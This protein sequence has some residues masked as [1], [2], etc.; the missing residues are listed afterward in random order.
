[1][2][3]KSHKSYDKYFFQRTHTHTAHIYLY[4]Y[5]YTCDLCHIYWKCV[6]LLSYDFF[7]ASGSCNLSP[8]NFLPL[9]HPASLAM[10]SGI[11]IQFQPPRCVV[12]IVMFS[13]ARLGEC[14][15]VCKSNINW[16][17]KAFNGH[18]ERTAKCF[19]LLSISFLFFFW[20]NFDVFTAFAF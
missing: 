6:M 17:L 8:S 1:M 3:K 12:V 10:M 9:S 4:T 18:M 13:L 7:C 15:G 19:S 20:N 11:D 14:A 16:H 5:I 2:F